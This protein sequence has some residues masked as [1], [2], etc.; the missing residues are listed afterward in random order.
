MN[1]TSR[2]PPQGSCSDSPIRAL[3]GRAS[4][5][6][7][8]RQRGA[9]HAR[10]ATTL[11]G[12]PWR[13]APRS[14]GGPGY[15]RPGR[16][17]ALASR[18]LAS[19]GLATCCLATSGGPGDR[20]PWRDPRAPRALA[21]AADACWGSIGRPAALR[22]SRRAPG[23]PGRAPGAPGCAPGAPEH[24]AVC[25]GAFRSTELR[26]AIHLGSQLVPPHERGP[27][28]G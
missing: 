12:G 24:S 20:R 9:W 6:A 18:G 3:S 17:A 27:Q 25:S 19:G 23:A 14:N 1:S 4:A 21:R 7:G 13:P 15:R 2:T 10:R 22:C 28:A 8:Q 16:T 26:V 5:G 11:P